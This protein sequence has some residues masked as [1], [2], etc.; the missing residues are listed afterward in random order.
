MP[1]TLQ[2]ESGD[3][4]P[5]DLQKIV[6]ELLTHQDPELRVG[7]ESFGMNPHDVR[8]GAIKIEAAGAGLDPAT[9]ALIVAFGAPPLVDI[10]KHLLLPRIR[11]RWGI[12]AV[13]KEI[14]GGCEE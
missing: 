5:H 3:R 2:Y 9:V 7:I 4:L 11:R 6:D 1:V 12:D 8:A 10:W 13:G 14:D